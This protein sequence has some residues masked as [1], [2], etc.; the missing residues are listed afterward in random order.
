MCLIAKGNS[1]VYDGESDDEECD[2]PPHVTET[3]KKIINKLLGAVTGLNQKT[4]FKNKV[5][6]SN[7]REIN[8]NFLFECNSKF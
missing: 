8:P 7:Y 3:L 4:E 1:K 5:L 2:I 6:D